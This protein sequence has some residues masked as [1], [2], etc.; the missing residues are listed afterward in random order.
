[1]SV[2]AHPLLAARR[3]LRSVPLLPDPLAYA[4]WLKWGQQGDSR[5]LACLRRDL[6]RQGFLD[7]SGD[8]SGAMA[9]LDTALRGQLRGWSAYQI[10]LAAAGVWLLSAQQRTGQRQG[11]RCWAKRTLERALMLAAE[12]PNT[13]TA[14]GAPMMLAC[15]L[16]MAQAVMFDDGGP[17]HDAQVRQAMNKVLLNPGFDALPLPWRQSAWRLASHLHLRAGRHTQSRHFLALM[18]QGQDGESVIARL[19][20][21]AAEV[22]PSTT[23][24]LRET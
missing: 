23:S 19:R 8:L 24:R 10:A 12:A 17:D 5:S 13:L 1:M 6:E 16:V 4:T 7:V 2:P 18:S 21:R 22:A 3:P 20:L 15:D 14:D 9:D 11:E